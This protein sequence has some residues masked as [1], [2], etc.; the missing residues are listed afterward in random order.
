MLSIDTIRRTFLNELPLASDID[1]HHLQASEL[2]QAQIVLS[3][4]H[5]C[6]ATY[7]ITSTFGPAQCFL[8]LRNQRLIANNT[9][10]TKIGPQ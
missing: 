2:S 7:L 8:A 10:A 5:S 1:K 9:T 3:F 6:A 4:T